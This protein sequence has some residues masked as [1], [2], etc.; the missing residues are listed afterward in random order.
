MAGSRPRRSIAYKAAGRDGGQVLRKSGAPEPIP[1]GA[2]FDELPSMET[3]DAA[4]SAH[5]KWLGSSEQQQTQWGPWGQLGK[6]PP[7][8]LYSRSQTSGDQQQW[9]AK[10]VLEDGTEVHLAADGTVQEDMNVFDSRQALETA[11]AAYQEKAER[12]DVPEPTGRTPSTPKGGPS[13]SSGGPGGTLG[14]IGSIVTSNPLIAIGAVV[15]IWYLY[16]QYG[17][18]LIDG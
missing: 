13:G 16:R 4:R 11:F 9:I 15:V 14:S 3:E 2:S 7:W 5:Q 12:G 17:G 6:R 18:E 10:G 1:E 8:V